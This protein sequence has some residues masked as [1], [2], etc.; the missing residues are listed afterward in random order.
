MSPQPEDPLPAT[1][2]P[3]LVPTPQP[4]LPDAA[5]NVQATPGTSKAQR[6]LLQKKK[7]RRSR[8]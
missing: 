5:H 1:A 6:W 8:S 2:G 7:I 3:H 4:P